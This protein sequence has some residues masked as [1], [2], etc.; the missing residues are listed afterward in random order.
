MLLTT[1]HNCTYEWICCEALS[2]LGRVAP[3]IAHYAVRRA[4]D[5]DRSSSQSSAVPI[6][7]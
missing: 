1:A 2:G 3:D 4:S 6:N 7:V 5:R